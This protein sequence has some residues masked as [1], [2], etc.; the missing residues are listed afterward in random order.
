MRNIYLAKNKEDR[1][2]QKDIPTVGK[3]LPYFLELC[4]FGHTDILPNY[5]VVNDL[6]KITAPT[7]LLAGENDWINNVKYAYQM[8]ELIS[9]SE[10]VVFPKAGHFIWQGIESEFY[11]IIAT[12]VSQ[13]IIK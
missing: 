10:L 5:N 3:K 12:F 8:H 6:H 2:E 7:L 1:E 13:K 9:D 4:N 11:E